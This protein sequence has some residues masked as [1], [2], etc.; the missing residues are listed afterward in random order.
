MA[1]NQFQIHG[2]DI[3]ASFLKLLEVPC[4]TCRVILKGSVCT[5]ARCQKYVNFKKDANGREGRVG[6][7]PRH[8]TRFVVPEAERS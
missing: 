7:V 4:L 6:E 3:T 1:G 5:S 2:S 8:N